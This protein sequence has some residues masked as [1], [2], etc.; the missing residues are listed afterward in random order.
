MDNIPEIKPR[1]AHERLCAVIRRLARERSTGAAEQIGKLLKQAEEPLD[2]WTA[3]A[4]GEYLFPGEGTLTPGK[5]PASL[6]EKFEKCLKVAWTYGALQRLV[7]HGNGRVTNM[8]DAKLV[9]T[10]LLERCGTTTLNKIIKGKRPMGRVVEWARNGVEPTKE[11]FE[12]L[13]RDFVED[14]SP[15]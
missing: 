10:E 8:A 4:V 6:R 11:E 14:G 12:Q 15:I 2:V 5:D 13:W 7:D 1:T 9:T 3:Q